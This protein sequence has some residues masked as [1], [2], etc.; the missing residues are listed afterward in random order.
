MNEPPT[1]PGNISLN[2]NR[3]GEV[4]PEGFG[5][6]PRSV[7]MDARTTITKY[8]ESLRA[9]D[10][11][12]RFFADE[13]SE[14]DPYVKFGISE[15]LVGS[16]QIEA[17]LRSQTETTTDWAVTSHELQVTEREEHAWFG[18]TVSMAWTNVETEKRLEYET[19]WSG[20]L[21]KRA[22]DWTF[23]GMHVSTADQL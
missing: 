6:R 20:T 11:L 15:H 18:D 2:W 16:D 14:D 7:G 4:Y 3:D 12:G 13:R 19:R 21:E 22:A 23:V 17:G 5:R 1:T 10:P 9:G 8:Y